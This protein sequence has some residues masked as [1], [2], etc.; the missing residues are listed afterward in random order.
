VIHAGAVLGSDGFG[1]APHE[2]RLVKIPQVGK[3]VVEEGVEIGANTTVDRATLEETRIGAESKLDNLVQVGHN[4]RLGPGCVI[5]G[6]AGIAGSARLGRGVVMGG[7][8]GAIGHVEIGDG[9]QIAGGAG[10]MQGLP[11][12]ARV[13]GT[14]AVELGHWRRQTVWVSRLG[15]LFRRVRALERR[16]RGGKD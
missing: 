16:G 9:V 14:P 11:A 3:L 1:Y 5:C 15:E 8:S 7:Q 4:V 2:G 13:A 12:G 10:A 6:Q